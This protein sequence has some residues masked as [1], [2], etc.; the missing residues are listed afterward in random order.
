[1]KSEEDIRFHKAILAG[2]REEL[3]ETEEKIP[4]ALAIRKSVYDYFNLYESR[5]KSD[6]D[7]LLDKARAEIEEL[8]RAE[9]RKQERQQEFSER[10]RNSRPDSRTAR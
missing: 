1:M 9:E 3:S 5:M 8:R 2:L 10:S 7:I 6:Y 4:E